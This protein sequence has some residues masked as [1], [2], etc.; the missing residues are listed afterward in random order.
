MSATPNITL[1]ARLNDIL[2]NADNGAVLHIELVGFGSQIPKAGASVIARTSDDLTV[3]GGL[4]VAVIWGNDQITPAGTYYIMQVRDDNGNVI[5][6]NSYQLMGGPRTVDLATEPSFN[7]P[8]LPSYPP[9]IDI[10]YSANPVIDLSLGFFFR[11]T[12][13]GDATF[14]ATNPVAIGQEFAVLLL[15]DGVGGHHVTWSGILAGNVDVDPTASKKNLFKFK[16][17]GSQALLTG[18]PIGGQ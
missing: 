11:M 1:N 14:T 15:Q 7:P 18:A 12:L 3:S 6:T 2:N 16:Y 17:D 9:I 10:P 4:V 13:T 8:P 5:Q